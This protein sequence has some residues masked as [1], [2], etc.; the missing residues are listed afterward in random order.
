MN[1]LYHS[2]NL[3]FIVLLSQSLAFSKDVVDR[4]LVVV[5]SEIVLQSDLKKLQDRIRRCLQS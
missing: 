3:F 2:K 4:I 5:N 1:A